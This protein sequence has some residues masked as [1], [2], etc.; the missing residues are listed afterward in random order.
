MKASI[1]LD[2]LLVVYGVVNIRIIS[3]AMQ[4]GNY[5]TNPQI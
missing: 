3:L 5:F 2:L 4:Q 1:R